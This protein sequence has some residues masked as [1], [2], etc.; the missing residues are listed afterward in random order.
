[1]DEGSLCCYHLAQPR[2]TP[3]PK[4]KPEMT[5]I[6]VLFS[7]SLKCQFQH[8]HDLPQIHVLCPQELQTSP[9][10]ACMAVMSLKT[11]IRRWALTIM[12]VTLNT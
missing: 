8:S 4:R 12:T 1:M 3:L 6:N 2:E 5:V 10:T 9:F 7:L 11:F